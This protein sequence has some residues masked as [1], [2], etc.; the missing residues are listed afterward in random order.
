MAW[1]QLALFANTDDADKIGDTLTEIGAVAVTMSDGADEEIFEPP[2][3]E[4]PLWQSTIVIGLFDDNHTPDS[5]ITHLRA[6]LSQILPLYEFSRL[7][8]KDWE[9]AWLDE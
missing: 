7:E 6:N 2:L 3:G 5:I 4:M 8:D 1:I 9:R